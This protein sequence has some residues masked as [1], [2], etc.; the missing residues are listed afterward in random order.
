MDGHE[1]QGDV[2]IQGG[3]ETEGANNDPGTDSNASATIIDGKTVNEIAALQGHSTAVSEDTAPQDANVAEQ[4][5]TSRT[6]SAKEDDSKPSSS[7]KGSE[8]ACTKAID[9][10]ERKRNREK[11]RRLDTNS[12]FTT[13]AAI[14]REIET[15][16]FMEEAQLNSLYELTQPSQTADADSNKK[17]KSDT[18][19]PGGTIQNTISTTGTYS[20]SNRV[21]LIARTTLMLSQFRDIRKKRNAELRDAR[22]QNCEMK[23]E[24]EDLRRM[25]AHYKAVGMGQQKPQDKVCVTKLCSEC[26]LSKHNYCHELST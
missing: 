25:V 26:V 10:I 5:P 11:Q 19:F 9:R 2:I 1:S 23:K 18:S 22:R 16:D 7:P 12:Q 13:L 4:P 20:A 6:A 14:V 17:L 15:T 8:E 24:V 21:E 3:G